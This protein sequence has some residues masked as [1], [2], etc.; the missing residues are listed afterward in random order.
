VVT[1]T[2]C[3]V[4]FDL[5]AT[6]RRAARAQRSRVGND[7]RGERG[8][9]SS[10]AECARQA[11]LTES[12]AGNTV[13]GGP[14]GCI[15]RSSAHSRSPYDLGFDHDLT[16]ESAKN[17]GIAVAVGLVA[18]MVVLASRSERHRQDHQPRA[19][20]WLAFGVWTQR[21]SLQDCADKVKLAVFS[22][23]PPACRSRAI[24]T[25][26]QR[27]EPTSPP[28]W[29]DLVQQRLDHR[30]SEQI[31]MTQ[32]CVVATVGQLDARTAEQRRCIA[33]L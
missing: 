26:P 4:P 27:Q 16:L 13:L 25:C 24:S 11:P 30:R 7:H 12:L 23:T 28:R 33:S 18:L 2:E 3:G 1:D 9:S 15:G 10:G 21:S 8:R 17:I 29:T 14:D 31:W 22:A 5:V 32:W 20:R 6:C 19:G